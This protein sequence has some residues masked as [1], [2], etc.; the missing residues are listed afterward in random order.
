MNRIQTTYSM[1]ESEIDKKWFLIDAE[2]KI[3]GR[4]ASEVA[5]ILRGKNKPDFTPHLD[6][7]DNVVVINAEKVA[8]TGQKSEDKKYF[9]HS[10]YPG[11]DKFIS[12]KKILEKKPE[13]VIQHAVK[14]MIPKNRL[15]SQLMTNLKVYAGKDHPHQAQSPEKIDI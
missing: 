15:G 3:L 10:Q 12:I 9:T 2:G 1:K 7:G 11:G 14:G 13:Y 4:L 8:L 6:M 5:R